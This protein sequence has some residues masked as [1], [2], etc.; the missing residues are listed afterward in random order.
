MK[1][2]HLL[3][4][5]CALSFSIA[6]ANAGEDPLDAPHMSLAAA[7][8]IPVALERFRNDQPKAVVA[9]FSVYIREQTEAVEVEFVP[10]ASPLDS[11]CGDK[12]CA[13]SVDSG[14]SVYGYGLT[15]VIQ[16]STHRILK[17]I[18]SR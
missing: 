10:D 11:K 6:A 12:D 2:Q 7:Q 15:Y 14:S 13:V 5:F 3:F 17:V 4:V 9:H 18:R 1:A 8:S 16:K